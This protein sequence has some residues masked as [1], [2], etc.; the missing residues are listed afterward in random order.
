[1]KKL[2]ILLVAT[3]ATLLSAA[4]I[5]KITGTVLSQDDN[6][7]VHNAVVALLTP[8]DSILYKFTRTDAA[9]KF[10]LNDIKKGTY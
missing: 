8:K 3:F 6:K 4:Q 5:S 2:T 9:G 7:P 10:M 1:M